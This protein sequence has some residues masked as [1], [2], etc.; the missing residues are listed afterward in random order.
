M[1]FETYDYLKSVLNAHKDVYLTEQP[2]L[3]LLTVSIKTLPGIDCK[4]EKRPA[5]YVEVTTIIHS[6]CALYSYEDEVNGLIS[7]IKR[8]YPETHSLNDLREYIILKSIVN[9]LEDSILHSNEY[10][11]WSGDYKKH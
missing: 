11:P 2:G 7:K 8:S 10:N 4:K 6:G 1:V 5:K 3:D 9:S